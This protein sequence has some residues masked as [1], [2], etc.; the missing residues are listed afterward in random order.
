MKKVYKAY[1]LKSFK[2]SYQPQNTHHNRCIYLTCSYALSHSNVMSTLFLFYKTDI[3]VAATLQYI[4]KL[5]RS[6]SMR[7]FLIFFIKFWL[8][9]FY[10][11][12]YRIVLLFLEGSK[13]FKKKEVEISTRD[14]IIKITLGNFSFAYFHSP[15]CESLTCNSLVLV[16]EHFQHVFGF[17]RFQAYNRHIMFFL[18]CI[19]T[20]GWNM[21]FTSAFASSREVQNTFPSKRKRLC[22][23][24]A[25]KI[26]PT[27]CHRHTERLTLHSVTTY[28]MLFIN[29]MHMKTRV[30]NPQLV[31]VTS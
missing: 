16:P 21:S 23:S 11:L 17:V 7:N 12:V 13:N 3:V 29:F 25:C 1:K 31:F 4:F 9:L 5:I 27:R 24:L 30:S 6:V 20:F 8:K 22:R 15:T 2:F 14:T 10:N 19:F 26:M 28:F 18:V